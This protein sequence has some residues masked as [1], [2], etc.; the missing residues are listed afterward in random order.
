[1]TFE[2]AYF[3]QKVLKHDSLE[4]FGFITSE[5]GY[6]LRKPQW[7]KDLRLDYSLI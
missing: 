5:K 3:K 6:E 7:L 2:D 4:P 1:M